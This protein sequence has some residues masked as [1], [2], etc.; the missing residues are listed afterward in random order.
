METKISA[1]QAEFE[2]RATDMLASTWRTLQQWSSSRPRNSA[3]PTAKCEARS[4]T[5]EWHRQMLSNTTRHTGCDPTRPASLTSRVGDAAKGSRRPIASYGGGGN[6]RTSA[7]RV[8]PPKF[9]GSAS[10]AVSH[11]H[12][13]AAAGH[14]RT[15]CEDIVEAL[16]GR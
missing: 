7:D 9:N 8:K 4:G 3:S 15:S 11:R 14:K 1:G 10:S 6:A 13:E 5:P 2:E 16:K 12:F